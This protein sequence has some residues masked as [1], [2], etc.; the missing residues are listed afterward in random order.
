[1]KPA[2]IFIGVWNTTNDDG[3]VFVFSPHFN[4]LRLQGRERVAG[5]NR[6]CRGDND[7]LGDG[8]QKDKSGYSRNS[9]EFCSHRVL[10]V[11]YG[12]IIPHTIAHTHTHTPRRVTEE[13]S[14]TSRNDGSEDGE[15]YKA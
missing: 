14:K 15:N 6:R 11:L 3:S 4:F 13:A 2:I 1:M 7:G 12:G 5:G 9:E 10:I 8:V